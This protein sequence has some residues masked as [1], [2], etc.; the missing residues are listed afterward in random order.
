L[1]AVGWDIYKAALADAPE[2]MAV[3]TQPAPEEPS[4]A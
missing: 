1:R 2:I 3:C 4:D